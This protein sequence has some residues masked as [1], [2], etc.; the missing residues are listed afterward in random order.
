[1]GLSWVSHST[2]IYTSKLILCSTFNE[3]VVRLEMA[4]EL[5]RSQTSL[6]LQRWWVRKGGR[7]GERSRVV[8]LLFFHLPVVPRV[9][10]PSFS[11]FEHTCLRLTSEEEVDNRGLYERYSRV[12]LHW[13]QVSS[14]DNGKELIIMAEYL[15]LSQLKLWS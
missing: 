3:G 11:C 13:I 9:L 15:V 7:V 6:S 4:T 1:M 2:L 12:Y 5:A 10:L 14:E 8:S